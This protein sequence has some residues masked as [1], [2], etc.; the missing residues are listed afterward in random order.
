MILETLRRLAKQIGLSDGRILDP[1]FDGRGSEVHRPMR[2]P[3]GWARLH[4]FAATFPDE[5]TAKAFCYGQGD[6]NVPEPITRELDGAT[7][8][9][10]Y[11]EIIQGDLRAR[12]EQFLEEEEI[13]DTLQ[14]SRPHNTLIILKEEAFSGLPFQVHDTETLHYIGVQPVQT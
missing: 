4:L 8:D 9:T 11:L 13:K 3:D 6:P 12:L 10:T 14:E 1:A 5:S 7:I 2:L